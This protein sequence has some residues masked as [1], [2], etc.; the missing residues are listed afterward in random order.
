MRLAANR[1]RSV[2]GRASVG[3]D[4]LEGRDRLQNAVLANLEVLSGE[5]GNRIAIAIENG[6][7]D[8]DDIGAGPERGRLLRLLGSDMPSMA[9]LT[10]SNRS[11]PS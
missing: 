5:R 2:V 10:T 3:D 6:R 9:P 7:V 11:M 4:E 1:Q 8:A